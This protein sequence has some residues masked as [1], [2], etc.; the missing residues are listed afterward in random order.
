M[1]WRDL[2]EAEGETIVAPWLGG[3]SVD[4]GPRRW[5]LSGSLPGEPGW[6]R[7][8][9]QGRNVEVDQPVEPEPGAFVSVVTGHLIGDR[10][11]TD[12]AVVDPDPAKIASA[13]ERVHLLERGLDRFV[14]ISAGRVVPEGPLIFKEE[15]MPLGPEEEVLA[16]WQDKKAS[17]DHVRG[18]P[19]SL[20]A[21]F[22]ME[23][24]QRSEAKRHREALER[25]RR[26]QEIAETLGDGAGRRKLAPRDFEAAAQAALAV[27]GAEYL[28]HRPSVARR[29]MVVR[30]RLAGRRFECTCDERTLRIIDAGVCLVDHHTD[31]RGDTYFTL[32]SLPGVIRQADREGVL[33]VFRHVDE[34]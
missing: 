13:S 8:R 11:V 10:L 16:A 6:Y 2:L 5:R 7:F 3:R 20:D 4:L 1:G 12:G 24:W 28:E 27:G 18:V 22:R 34:E 32:E 30:F 26:R 15:E 33:V 17:V 14:R 31:E 25:L 23:M 19:P 21:A 29:E 9:V